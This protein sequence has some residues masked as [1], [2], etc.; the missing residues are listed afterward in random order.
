MKLTL[1]TNNY[2]NKTISKEFDTGY[3]ITDVKIFQP[4]NILTPTFIVDAF[5]GIENYNYCYFD[6]FDRYYFMT[7]TLE[8]H[9]AYLSCTVDPLR[10]WK[11]SILNKNFMIARNEFE[12]NLMLPDPQLP[13]KSKP[14]VWSRN[15]AEHTPFGNAF[16][17]GD[18]LLLT[19]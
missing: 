18:I 14:V 1:H 5:S 13:L 8:N 11:D 17:G 9:K 7:V 16:R 6:K 4:C 15:D 3:D 2:D 19:L 12:Y 10:S